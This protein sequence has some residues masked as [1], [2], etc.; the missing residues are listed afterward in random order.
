MNIPQNGNYSLKIN[1]IQ[2]NE[3]RSLLTN[4]SILKGQYKIIWDGSNN[5][6]QAL[7][8]GVY[9]YNLLSQGKTIKSGKII[10]NR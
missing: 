1:G 6:S 2:G 10:L 9:I 8:S 7:P 3:V 5:Y 4:Q